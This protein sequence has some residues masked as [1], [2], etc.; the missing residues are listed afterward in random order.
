MFLLVNEFHYLTLMYG[1]AVRCKGIQ[2]GEVGLALMY[3]A[4]V[5]QQCSWPSW[6]SAHTGSH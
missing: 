4:H 2:D 1:P 5:E 6:I 3:P